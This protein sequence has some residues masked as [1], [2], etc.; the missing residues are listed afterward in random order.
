M[1]LGDF[2]YICTVKANGYIPVS[3]YKSK[4]TG[5]SVF[6]A[7]VDGPIVNGY[8]CLATEAHDDDGLPHTLEH[9]VFLGSEEYPYKGVL[10]MLANR[11]L[12]SGTNAWTNTDNTCYTVTTA[13]SEGFCNLLPIF[14]D[15]ILYPTLPR[16]GY[17]T[18]VH[19]IN[20][21][22]ED[23]GV[24]YSEMQ[25]RENTGESLAY[26]AMLR[27]VYPEGCGYRSETGGILKNLRTSTTY[28]KVCS[29]H[30]DFYRPENLCLIITGQLSN[31]DLFHQ[32]QKFEEKIVKKNNKAPFSRPWQ[33]S[34]TPLTGSLVK[35]ILYPSDED[36]HGLVLSAWRGPQA[37]QQK[38]VMALKILLEYLNDTPIAPLQ[39]DFVETKKPYCSMVSHEL[40]ENSVTL[41]Y[42]HF[43]SV[44]KENLTEIVPQLNK[45]L[46]K[47]SS[48]EEKIDMNRM[49]TV[50]KRKML[51]LLNCVE[52][53][54]H[55]TMAFIL[56]GD[57]L[58]GNNKDDLEIRTNPLSCY[59]ELDKKP[60]M[61]WVSLLQTYCVQNHNISIIATPSKSM[62]KQMSEAEQ[63]RLD[64][65]KSQLGK[66]GLDQKEKEL[67]EAIESNEIKPEDDI[68]SSL[69]VPDVSCI[70]FHPLRPYCNYRSKDCD[71]SD[72]FPIDDIP[73]KFQLDDLQTNFVQIT[74]VL[75][76]VN[77]PKELRYFLPLYLET[78]F[79]SP[80]LRNGELVSHKTIVAEL[81]SDT[82][83]NHASL[84]IDGS[85][86][87]C[88]SFSQALMI[89]LKVE[90]EKYHKGVQWLKELL[91]KVQF[92]KDRLKI[93]ATKIVN[94]VPMLKRRGPAVVRTVL[95][96]LLYNRDSNISVTSMLRQSKFLTDVLA[97]LDTNPD[98]VIEK[99]EKL[100]SVLTKGDNLCIHMTANLKLLKLDV[101]PEQ[102]WKTF[103]PDSC[104]QC[105]DKSRPFLR[106]TSEYI[107]PLEAIPNPHVIIGIGSEESAYLYLTVPVQISYDNP[108]LAILMVLL[109]YLT[110]CEGPMWKQIRGLGLSYS[111]NMT[112]NEESGLLCLVLGQSVNLI[113]SFKMAQN[114]VMSYILGESPYIELEL[115][116]ARSS[117]IFEIINQEKTTFDA[118]MASLKSYLKRVDHNYNRELL[119]KVA[120]VSIAD[121]KRVGPKYIP[122]LFDPAKNRCSVCCHPSK[123]EEVCNGLNQVNLKLDVLSSMNE[124]FLVNVC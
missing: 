119:G 53:E 77:I 107:Q 55:D 1:A 11:C 61:F 101:P 78:L 43:R 4:T 27:Y 109:Q 114:I 74:A 36:T 118:S 80:I 60:E 123:V 100:R 86:F 18:E 93:G 49:H 35:A 124:D 108:D 21:N 75:D 115:E 62:M 79:E 37:K 63:K 66:M 87:F 59:E 84:G 14:L 94:D 54:P 8:F 31:D 48:G 104:E 110:L 120:Q 6:L 105:T 71:K 112:I 33:S 34:I 92:T 9:L 90:R 56:M 99:M 121:L 116:S 17:I 7:A 2:E 83:E 26:L 3:K 117:L 72:V 113:E 16:S 23:A 22:G 111:Y 29:Y 89:S 39:R 51:D 88:G 82:L 58:F 30:K 57:F 19:H 97:Q 24:V 91:Y 45:T 41:F 103:I 69:P 32:L 122:N 47:I 76:T 15:H 65:Q 85:K 38:E 106:R 40:I 98:G 20:G 28:D 12:A 73:F 95:Y 13:G 70:Q 67:L 25:A 50:I 96:S 5:L 64:D 81:Q 42:F 44:P 102:P 46:E 52:T 10:D 68:L